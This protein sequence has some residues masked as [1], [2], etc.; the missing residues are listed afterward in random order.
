MRGLESRL[1]QAGQ[2]A[3]GRLGGEGPL[4]E[5]PDFDLRLLQKACLK[6]VSERAFLKLGLDLDPVF[7]LDPVPPA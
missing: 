7:R 6:Y 5:G 4:E 2:L 1:E 3:C